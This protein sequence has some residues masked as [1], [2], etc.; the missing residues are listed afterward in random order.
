MPKPPPEE[1]FRVT[2]NKVSKAQ[3]GPVMAEL[4]RLG[5][6]D[7]GFD[8]TTDIRAYSKRANHDIKGD[9]MLRE[10]VADNPT[11]T[12]QQA[13][14]HFKANGR[15]AGAV[16][17]AIKKLI[18]AG[19]IRRIG[20]GNYS[21]KGV[22]ALAPPKKVKHDLVHTAFIM[23]FAARRHGKIARLDLLEAFRDDGRNP[24]AISASLKSLM[25][26]GQVKRVGEGVYEV[27][28]GNGASHG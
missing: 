27:I 10:F 1:Y 23:R 14:A 17:Y 21:Q 22:K 13:T 16:Y 25:R 11:F 2:V 26:M 28:K 6:D 18:D 12:A 3:L 7:V 19:E 4:A 8:L 15:D 24:S 5:L 9:A 20:E